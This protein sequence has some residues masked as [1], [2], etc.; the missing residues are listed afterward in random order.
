ME[1]GESMN[2]KE[3]NFK[4]LQ[5]TT[6]AVNVL[7]EFEK[8]LN[9]KG[10]TLEGDINIKVTDLG[11]VIASVKMFLPVELI[12]CNAQPLLQEDRIPA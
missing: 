8:F 5:M 1:K 4:D 10:A 9:E 11:D 3:Y 2:N 6:K 7:Q 12:E